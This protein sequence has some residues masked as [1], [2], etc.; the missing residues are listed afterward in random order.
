M[1]LSIHSLQ[2]LPLLFICNSFDFLQPDGCEIVV[3]GLIFPWLLMM[4]KVCSHVICASPN[5]KFLY[6]F[7][8]IILS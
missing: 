3:C 2:E 5:T 7:K 4:L 8:I 6:T 1:I